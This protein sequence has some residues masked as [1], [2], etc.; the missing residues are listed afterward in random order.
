MGSA[1]TPSSGSMPTNSPRLRSSRRSR[2]RLKP[3]AIPS[4]PNCTR[5]QEVQEC[6][7]WEECQEVACQVQE[8]LL[9]EL[10]PA[11]DQPLR[12]STKFSSVQPSEVKIVFQTYVILLQPAFLFSIS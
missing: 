9:L 8:E 3:S 6:R 2:R 12:R 10:D 5:V 7:T 11:P 1:M 4:S